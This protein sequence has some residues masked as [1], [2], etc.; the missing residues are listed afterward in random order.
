[1]LISNHL[2]VLV[3]ITWPVSDGLNVFSDGLD[4]SYDLF[5]VLD[6]G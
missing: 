6:P 2:N 1:M 4:G 3:M 5:K